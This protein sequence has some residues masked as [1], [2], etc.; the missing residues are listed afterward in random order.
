MKDKILAVCT[1]DEAY[2]L[3]LQEALSERDA[4][5]FSVYIYTKPEPLNANT[6]ISLYLADEFFYEKISGAGEAAILLRGRENGPRA[7]R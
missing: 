1:A 2:A 6:K 4:F 5:P 3:R 7:G